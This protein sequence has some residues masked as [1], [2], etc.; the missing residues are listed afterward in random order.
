MAIKDILV[1]VDGGKSAP[2]R[3]AAAFTLAE[4][5]SDVILVDSMTH[6]WDGEGGVLA[7]S[8]LARR[9]ELGDY[10]LLGEGE[11]QRGGRSVFRFDQGLHRVALLDA[12]NAGGIAHLAHARRQRRAGR[13]G[14]DGDA[15]LADVARE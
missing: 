15:V 5:S 13:D 9:M 3:Y 1:Q 11:E 2:A 6:L 4:Q 14:V 8:A 10:L 12:F 7:L